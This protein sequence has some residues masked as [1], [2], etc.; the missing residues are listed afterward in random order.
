MNVLWDQDQAGI[1]QLRVALYTIWGISLGGI[2]FFLCFLLLPLEGKGYLTRLEKVRF[3]G[4]FLA[5][6]LRAFGQYR[7]HPWAVV[8]AV[9]IGMA[10]HVGFV[11]SYYFA[12]LALPGPGPTP[13]WQVH[14]LIIPFFMVFQ[15]VP[16]T[17]GGNLGVG[18]LLL[19]GL[20][21]MLGASSIKGVLASLI[22]RV[23]A[24]AVALVGLIWYVPLHTRMRAGRKALASPGEPE[25]VEVAAV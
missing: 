2:L 1:A 13:S 23:L 24:W 6:A 8:N 4:R 25:P 18:D 17:F 15:A 11:L 5:K 20:Y 10:G 14:F 3:A 7:R 12:S 16:L 9:L 19:G 21:Q 22:Q